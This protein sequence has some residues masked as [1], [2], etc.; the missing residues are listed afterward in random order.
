MAQC[1]AE[2]HVAG[3]D[4]LG[5]VHTCFRPSVGIAMHCTFYA[6]PIV[7][8]PSF[9]AAAVEQWGYSG[10]RWQHQACVLQTLN[11]P[12]PWTFPVTWVCL[13]FLVCCIWKSL[14]RFIW[15][16]EEEITHLKF[17]NKRMVLWE[18]HPPHSHIKRMLECTMTP[19]YHWHWNDKVD[20]TMNAI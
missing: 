14:L 3:D 11:A 1:S 4:L 9:S 15:G 8:Q 12:H 10:S 5:A 6:G 2:A 13:L 18:W 19:F 16:Q 7:I 20:K 17:K